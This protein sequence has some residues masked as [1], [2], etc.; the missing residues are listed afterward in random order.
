M[1]SREDV[2]RSVCD[3]VD[4]RAEHL[5]TSDRGVALPRT[6]LQREIET[7]R[8]GLD[9]VGVIRD[10]N[11]EPVDTCFRNYVEVVRQYPRTGRPLNPEVGA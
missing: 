4:R 7:V 2:K 3:A 6:M 9:P 1:P 10:P 8:E 5:A 11:H